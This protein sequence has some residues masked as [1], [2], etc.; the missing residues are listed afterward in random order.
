MKLEF[1]YYY[2]SQADQ[3]NFIKIPKTMI[4][5]PLF[6]NLSLTSKVLYGILL[7]RMNLSMKNHWLD[8]ENRVYIIYQI[9]EIQEDM[10][11]SKKKAIEYL[12]EL[13][14]F[15]LVEK[16]RRGL[17]L[18]SLLYVKSFIVEK[19]DTS[20]DEDSISED[21]LREGNKTS[22]SVEMGTSRGVKMRTSRSSENGSSRSVKM[23]PQEVPDMVPPINNTYKSNTKEN[24]TES[25]LILSEREVDYVDKIDEMENINN[26]NGLNEISA[27]DNCNELCEEKNSNNQ[28]GIDELE[29][30]T[31]I[32]KENIE[33]KQILHQYSYDEELIQGI[34][35]LILETVISQN[36]YI[37]IAS[38]KYPMALVKSKFLKLNKSHVEYVINSMKTNTT[39]IK[40][41][42]KYLLAALFNASTTIE[43]YYQAEV[44]H[45]M[46]YL[47]SK[48]EENGKSN[49][50]D[51]DE[52]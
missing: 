52:K 43:G 7:D 10:G 41:I 20:V 31:E 25:N 36:K 51:L 21:S 13:E 24:N 6:A 32:I 29:I 37:I 2:G 35:Q 30:Y 11:L 38:D 28:N 23:K 39:K 50:I 22:R 18:P 19:V 49:D 46:P 47:V 42:K 4:I 9:A 26:Q 12:S 14:K 8:G 40:N 5:D 33:Y 27:M 15:G 34:F 3:F 17:G 1:N 48:K 44:N 45:D 16:K